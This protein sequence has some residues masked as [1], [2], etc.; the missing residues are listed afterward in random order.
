MV[1]E[2]A[3]AILGSAKRPMIIAGGGVHYSGAVE[4]LPAFAEK[5]AIPVVEIVAGK[6]TPRLDEN[7]EAVADEAGAPGLAR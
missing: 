6:S 2:R 4:E 7:G 3:A 1:L 5:H